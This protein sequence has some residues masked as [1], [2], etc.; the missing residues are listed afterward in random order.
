M[1]AFILAHGDQSRL[2]SRLPMPKQFLGVCGETIIGRTI[3]LL[4]LEGITDIAV[5]APASGPWPGFCESNGIALIQDPY[6]S[7]AM[8]AV[9]CMSR[10][11]DGKLVLLG[12]V[13]FSRAC[14]RQALSIKT[15]L[16]FVGRR[17]GNPVTK[18]SYGELY[19]LKYDRVG[20]MYAAVKLK[21][22]MAVRWK[23]WSLLGALGGDRLLTIVSDYT[24]D[25]DTPQDISRIYLVE[26]AIRKDALDAHPR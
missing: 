19:G 25:V 17:D 2:L 10:S 22:P 8:A 24:D 21:T 6:P 14:I 16:G 15:S 4:R 7:V 5:L 26:D 23:L 18:K 3:R 20:A 12:D 1:K 13:I 9:A 11:M